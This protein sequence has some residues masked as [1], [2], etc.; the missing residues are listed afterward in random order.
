MHLHRLR[1]EF[2]FDFAD[3]IASILFFVFLK[4]GQRKSYSVSIFY[5]KSVSYQIMQIFTINLFKTRMHC[6]GMRTVRFSGRLSCAHA[7]PPLS[8]MPLPSTPPLPYMPPLCHACPLHHANIIF[9][10][11][12]LRA[13][14][15]FDKRV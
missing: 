4:C 12:R 10:Q 9:P 3:N 1:G 6:S 8:H 5:L 15:S 14:I 11:L 13:V 2:V 7:P